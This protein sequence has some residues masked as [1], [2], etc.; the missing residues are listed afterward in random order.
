VGGRE[1][2]LTLLIP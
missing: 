2:S 1:E